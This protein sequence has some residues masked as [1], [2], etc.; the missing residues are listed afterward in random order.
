M[1]LSGH[2]SHLLKP[3][4]VLPPHEEL[5]GVVDGG[6]RV[7][8][9]VDRADGDVVGPAE[10]VATKQGAGNLGRATVKRGKVYEVTDRDNDK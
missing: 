8:A 3:H 1:E 6:A 4:L 7:D 5:A 10:M 9:G 2:I